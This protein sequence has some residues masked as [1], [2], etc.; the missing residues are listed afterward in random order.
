MSFFQRF[1]ESWRNARGG[2]PVQ[3]ATITTASSGV[4]LS[5]FFNIVNPSSGYLV[6]ESTAMTVATVYRCCAIIGGAVAQLPARQFREV[7]GERDSIKTPLW[8]LLN[9]SPH[10]R[11]TSAAWKEMIVRSVLMR[12]DSYAWLQNH[13][14]NGVPRRIEPLRYSQVQVYRDGDDLIYA[15]TDEN[16]KI[17]GV[18]SSD[19]LHFTG[20]GFDG[21][22][23]LSVMQWAAKQG[24]GNA[25]AAADYAG[26]TF[27]EGAIPQIALKY[28]NKFTKD[29][30]DALRASFVSTYGGNGSGGKRVPLVL[31]EGGDVQE[32]SLTPQD[33]Q[34]IETRKYERNDI[35]AAFGVPPIML[36][37]NEKTTSWG[38][39]IEQITIGFVDYTL[40]PH[41]VRWEE[42]LNRKLFKRAGQ[43]IEFDVNGL[44]RGDSTAQSNYF[45]AALGGP[46]SG[47]GWMSVNEVRK[48]SN[49]PP[50]VGGEK[51]FYPESTN[52]KQ[53]T[54]A[55]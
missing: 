9:E 42:E 53:T 7:N 14:V 49:L 22:R 37:D 8:W 21:Y 54:G 46:G 45:K 28:P 55:A 15:V 12:G 13:D 4:E 43:F 30:A 10:P 17:H 41:L 35:A 47:P 11:W 38:T 1:A 40:K 27:A 5:E 29:Q 26:K 39:G 36:G 32:L 18:Q 23:S 52:A 34:L 3:N 19:M 31:G 16:G 25:L 44:L 51:P 20:F 48:L 24:I 50:I 2:A 33:A 6:N